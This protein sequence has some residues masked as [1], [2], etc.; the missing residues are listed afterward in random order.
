M[1]FRVPSN[2]KRC[3]L[4]HSLHPRSVQ[5]LKEQPQNGR[6]GRNLRERRSAER[7]GWEGAQSPPSSIPAAGWLPPPA[8]GP[9]APRLTSATSSHHISPAKA[10]DASR[11][12]GL[13]A[14]RSDTASSQGRM[15]GFGGEPRIQAAAAGGARDP[16]CPSGRGAEPHHS[17]APSPPPAPLQDPLWAPVY[18]EGDVGQP[19]EQRQPP[20]SK[21]SS[22]LSQGALITAPRYR[23]SLA[24]LVSQPRS[25]KDTQFAPLLSQ[26]QHS[27]A[28]GNTQSYLGPHPGPD[29]RLLRVWE[30]R[31]CSLS[32]LAA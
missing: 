15:F 19:H 8:G 20:A 12:R 17:R 5:R 7:L 28:A 31:G 25:P 14:L 24:S 23:S 10:R 30:H 18:P 32:S 26:P 9:R 22:S 3:F 11:S 29:P 27:E 21:L 6:V 1:I 4:K 16:S 2:P 13:T